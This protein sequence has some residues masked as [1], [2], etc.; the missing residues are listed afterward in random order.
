MLHKVDLVDW[1]WL[2]VVKCAQSG[3]NVISKIKKKKFEKKFREKTTFKV[4]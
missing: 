3:F 4:K 2:N 1:M